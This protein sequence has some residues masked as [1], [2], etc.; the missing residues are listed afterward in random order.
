MGGGANEHGS[1]LESATL[2]TMFEPHFRL[3]P[4]LLGWGLGLARA[5]AG[6]HRVPGN[7]YTREELERAVWL[8]TL[9]LP[10]ESIARELPRHSADSI[11]L[12]L[13]GVGGA[14][15]IHSSEIERRLAEE[16]DQMPRFTGWREA[17]AARTR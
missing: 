12:A 9:G 7:L 11:H 4:R 16:L 8:A 3:D 15:G 2:A 6:T 1:V 5:E 17:L 10:L 13:L 14:P